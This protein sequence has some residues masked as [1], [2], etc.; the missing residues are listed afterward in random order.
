MAQSNIPSTCFFMILCLSL[1]IHTQSCDKSQ[2]RSEKAALFVFGDS[3]FDV[4]NNN[5]FN[6]SSRANYHPYGETFF[7]YPTGRFSNGRLI[8]D[9]ITEYAELPL[10]PPYLQPGYIDYRKGVNFASA[11]AGALLETRQGFVISLKTQI[12]YFKNVSRLLREKLGEAEAITL[13]SKAVFLFSVGA[14]DYSFLFDTNSSALDS[15]SRE[16]FVGLVIGNISSAIEEI[17]KTGGRK[18]GLQNV[19]PMA[20]VPY[21]RVVAAAKYNMSCL[22]QTTPFVQSHNK[23]LSKL[24]LKLNNQL[25][26]FRF[27]FSDYF[28]FVKERMDHPLKY[29]FKEGMVAC[30]GSGPYRGIFSCGG[31]IVKEYYLCGNVSEYVFFDSAH[32]TERA[33]QQFAE[34]AWNGKASLKGS[35]NLKQLFKS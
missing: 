12:G 16:E 9:F 34:Q 31:K 33:Y 22:D 21:A 13:L 35:Y 15:F 18:F 1:V 8:P 27:S 19:R 28:T 10:L 25:R 26:G 2:S 20:C 11:G 30:C 3:S 32:P 23:E 4:G 14:N 5:Y 24:L 29:G 6:T 7:K 17:Y